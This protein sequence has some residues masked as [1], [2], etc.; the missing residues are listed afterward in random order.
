MKKLQ[1]SRY[2]SMTKVLGEMTMHP[3]FVS[4]NIK[5]QI[6]LCKVK[7]CGSVHL[8]LLRYGSHTR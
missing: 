3:R 8:F 2:N 1:T 6:L 7:I 4:F 5:C